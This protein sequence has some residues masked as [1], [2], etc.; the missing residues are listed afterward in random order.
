MT[1][2]TFKSNNESKTTDFGLA[3][4]RITKKIS[5]KRIEK[6]FNE[7]NKLLFVFD[8][9]EK[10]QE[11]TEAYWN[12]NLQVDALEIQNNT[13]LLKNRLKEELRNG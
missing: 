3:V 8:N 13:K 10:L 12:H 4:A 6:D 7:H 5:L 1:K 2:V 11:I 9:S